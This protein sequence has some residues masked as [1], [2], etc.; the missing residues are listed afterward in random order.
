MG[1]TMKS[2]STQLLRDERGAVLT[3]YIAVVGLV[4]VGFIVTMVAMGPVM[5]KQYQLTRNLVASPFP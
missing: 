4:A 1:D 2:V 5:V 3:E